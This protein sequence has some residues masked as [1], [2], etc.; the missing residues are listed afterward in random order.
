MQKFGNISNKSWAAIT[1]HAKACVIDDYN[2]Y[3]YHT[4]EQ[5]VGLLFNSVYMLVGVIFDGHNY[6][7]PDTLTPNEK[8]YFISITTWL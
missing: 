2:L 6:C 7:S 8:V 4:A 3:I 1:E 5:P